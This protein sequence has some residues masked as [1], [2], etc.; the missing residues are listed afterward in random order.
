MK[1]QMWM[2]QLGLLLLWHEAHPEHFILGISDVCSHPSKYLSPEVTGCAHVHMVAKFYFFASK[3]SSSSLHRTVISDC[4]QRWCQKYIISVYKRRKCYWS[5]I[6][7]TLFTCD[8]MCSCE[9]KF[10]KLEKLHDD[11][12][13]LGILYIGR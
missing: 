12:E 7:K 1:R 11:K 2:S 3:S 10:F 6:E 13:S 8:W 4:C 5:V 9:L